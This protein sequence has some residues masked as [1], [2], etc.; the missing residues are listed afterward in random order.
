MMVHGEA[1]KSTGA[2]V[3]LQ[4]QQTPVVCGADG[5]VLDHRGM[6]RS[7][8][9]AQSMRIIVAWWNSPE[10]SG[11]DNGAKSGEGAALR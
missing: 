9:A 5:E 2:V 11:G 3:V 8:V 7:E 1:A 6:E 10:A 4:W